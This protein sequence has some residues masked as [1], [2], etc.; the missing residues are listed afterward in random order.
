MK[1][2]VVLDLLR[3]SLKEHEEGYILFENEDEWRKLFFK[4]GKIT[5]ASSSS[6]SDY[7]GQYMISFGVI[8]VEQFEEAYKEGHETKENMEAVIQYAAPEVLSMLI[9][10]KVINSIFV[11]TRWPEGE[12][13]VVCEKQE[14]YFDVD[15][16]LSV[17]D[18]ESGLKERIV[19]FQGIL[20]TVPELGGRPK[21][22]YM[23]SRGYEISHQK[24]IILNHLVAGKTL[25]EILEILPAH[26]YLLFKC[27]YKLIRM[28]ILLKGP[29]VPLSKEDVL[30]L[31]NRSE[32]SKKPAPQVMN[33]SLDASTVEKAYVEMG[34]NKYR[35]AIA[36]YQKLTEVYPNNPLYAHMCDQAKSC[37][38]VL[39]YNNRLSPFSVVELVGDIKDVPNVSELDTE[40][41]YEL[42]KNEDKRSSVRRII[43][44]MDDR[45][46]IDILTSLSKL[47]E[48]GFIKE[49]EPDTLINAIK[50]GRNDIYEDLFKK[51]EKN[52]L[53]DVNV[54]DNLT[55]L[56]LSS[57]TGNYPEEIAEEFGA[58]KF[59]KGAEPVLHDYKMTP[60]MLASMLGNYEAAEF[61]L[62]KNVK[63]EKNNGN[64]V[65]AL[66]LA[67]ENR[68][69]DVALL[70]I[71]KGADVNAKNKNN[72]S[73]L[74]IATAKGLSHVVDYMIR[75]DVDV[76]Q[77]NANGQTALITALRFNH[78]DIVVSLI[79]AGTDLVSKDFSGNEPIYYAESV[80]VTELIRKGAKFS[81]QIK[82]KRVKRKR[83]ELK[84]YK[85]N[86]V[87]DEKH[88]L[89]GSFPV[90]I[91]AML[92]LATAS[93]NVYLIFFSDD[94]YKMS[95][96]AEGVMEQLGSDYCV[97]FKECRKNVPQ[98][99]LD[100]CN[101]MGTDVVSE[102][103]KY[104][105]SC[106]SEMIKDC[107]SCLT[108]LKCSEFDE[109]SGMNLS[110]HC[111][112]C[113]NA[114]S[115]HK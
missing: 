111:Y 44:S 66:M 45:N 115:Y 26:N 35:T 60:L 76:N 39:F 113:V 8:N 6:K 54:T 52:S 28:G 2:A 43:K 33:F 31:V 105:Q 40:L 41:F 9:I 67:L 34:E 22:D 70:L 63:T 90:F 103:F 62:S 13:S 16:E 114:C 78:E 99:V 82:K 68:H 89:P 75:L 7:L 61:L 102:Y 69:D 20:E 59:E 81:Q 106:N 108:S 73:A 74:M 14:K 23:E 72:Y 30:E 10:E 17:K 42:Q 91:F 36:R 109:I 100:K 112:Q 86:L 3:N 95:P 25:V 88:V 58:Q 101:K 55:P 93:I 19:E 97:K 27:I 46:E 4:D 84:A 50:L 5:S 1:D 29:G 47:M 56:M 104:A 98:H 107:S 83:K 71:R 21:I 37:F 11:A 79:A 18:I 110:D 64:G 32:K 12:Y 38:V 48:S 53:F 92:V 15:I 49:S 77:I 51:K 94:R 24:E 57:V 65:T 87:K 96:Q 80:V 85:R